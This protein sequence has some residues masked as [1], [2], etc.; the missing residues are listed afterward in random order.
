MS[1]VVALSLDVMRV[2]LMELMMGALKVTRRKRIK[3]VTAATQHHSCALHSIDS[4]A[5]SDVQTP[6]VRLRELTAEEDG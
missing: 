6:Q 5:H 4:I 2:K 1:N 3:P